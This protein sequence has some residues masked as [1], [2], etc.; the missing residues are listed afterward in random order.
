MSNRSHRKIF[1]LVEIMVVLCLVLT[2]IAITIFTYNFFKGMNLDTR[3]MQE[4]V[5]VKKRFF[6]RL[7]K[8]IRSAKEVVI[9]SDSLKIIKFSETKKGKII[10][11]KIT[12]E[13]YSEGLKRSEGKKTNFYKFKFPKSKGSEFSCKFNIVKKLLQIELKYRPSKKFEM[14]KSVKILKLPGKKL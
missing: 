3:H 14:Q 7:G 5:A 2:V 10:E 1:T 13:H 9:K 12:Y 8:D 6:T 4:L 11:L